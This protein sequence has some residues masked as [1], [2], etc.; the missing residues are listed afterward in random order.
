VKT[1]PVTLAV[2]GWE[3]F[4]ASSASGMLRKPA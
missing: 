3:G 1:D 2:D 4:S